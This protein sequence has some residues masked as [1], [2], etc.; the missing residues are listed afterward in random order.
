VLTEAFAEAGAIS[1]LAEDA[2]G[3]CELGAKDVPHLTHEDVQIIMLPE[4]TE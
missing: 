1:T 3:V 2:R 4:G